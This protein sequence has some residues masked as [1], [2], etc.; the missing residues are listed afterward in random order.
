MYNKTNKKCFRSRKTAYQKNLLRIVFWLPANISWKD[1]C[2]LAGSMF[3]IAEQKY[4]LSKILCWAALWNWPLDGKLSL[5]ALAAIL[6]IL[7]QSSP[8]RT[9]LARVSCF[10]SV[11]VAVESG[12]SQGQAA[13]QPVAR[14]QLRCNKFILIQ[15]KSQVMFFF[16]QFHAQTQVW[17]HRQGTS[18]FKWSL[19]LIDFIALSIS[20][21]NF[22]LEYV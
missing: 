17:R 2:I 8:G 18:W 13:F 19:N 7:V 4:L 6:M 15:V 22:A 10:L 21:I 14:A 1:I 20:N 5:S 16:L 11:C 9:S 3:Y 12:Y